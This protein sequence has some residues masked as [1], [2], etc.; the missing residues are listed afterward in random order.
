ML[1]LYNALFAGYWLKG[2]PSYTGLTEDGQEVREDCVSLI[3]RS[4]EDR[5][6]FND[7]PDDIL[8]AFP[9]FAGRV[10]YICEFDE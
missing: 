3:Y 8:S 1:D 4:S 5:C 9:S 10:G 2:E 6:Y 7:V